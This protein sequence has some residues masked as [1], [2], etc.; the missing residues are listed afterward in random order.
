M[1]VLA[2]EEEVWSIHILIDALGQND[3]HVANNTS[4]PGSATARE[5]QISYSYS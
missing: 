1:S 4:N 3:L 2:T 5:L